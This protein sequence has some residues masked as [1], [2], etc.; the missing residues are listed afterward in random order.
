MTQI[1]TNTE[2]NTKNARIPSVR[3]IKMVRNVI[4]ES[5]TSLTEKQ[6]MKRLP[7]PISSIDLRRVL[8]ILSRND[9]IG[10]TNKGTIIWT[11]ADTPMVKQLLK[12]S[13]LYPNP[14]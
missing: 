5:E 7:Q 14:N 4:K 9:Y 2:S 10:Y 3:I 8:R 1:N 6:L 12:E 11:A 13:I